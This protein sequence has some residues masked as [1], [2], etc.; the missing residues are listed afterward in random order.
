M[1][2]TPARS[3]LIFGTSY[4]QMRTHVRQP[5]HF[6]AMTDGHRTTD[7]E[8]IAAQDAG[9]PRRR[10]L[11]LDDR[12]L[13]ELRIVRDAGHEQSFGREIDGAQLDVRLQEPT[14][15]CRREP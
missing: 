13:Q 9:R 14:V 5:V 11:R 8:V 3:I 12:L 4:G 7:A 15:A 6:S 2:P 1:P 10:G